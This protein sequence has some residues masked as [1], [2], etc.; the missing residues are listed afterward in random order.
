MRNGF[1]VDAIAA[2]VAAADAAAQLRRNCGRS[3]GRTIAARRRR[4]NDAGRGE[5][6]AAVGLAPRKDE[7]WREEEIREEE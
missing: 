5:D 2:A 6:R 1:N 3:C 4:S 7:E